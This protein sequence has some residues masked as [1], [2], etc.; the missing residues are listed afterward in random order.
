MTDFFAH[1]NEALLKC[2]TGA[3][4]DDA[5]KAAIVTVRHSH[6]HHGKLMFVGN[7]GS[8]AI[9]SHQAIDWT[10]NGGYRAICFNDA[11]ALS[12]LANDLGVAQMFAMPVRKFARA[13][14]VLFA[15]SSSGKSDNILEAVKA[16]LFADAKVITFSGFARDNPLRAMGDLNFYV[17]SDDYG[18]VECAHLAL[19]HSMLYEAMKS[20]A[21]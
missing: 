8:A 6:E 1:M 20:H 13:G 11:A 15:I 18:V 16:A 19:I 14:D 5:I 9:A 17:P 12:C 7:G 4:R 10:K 2:E 3:L 21:Q